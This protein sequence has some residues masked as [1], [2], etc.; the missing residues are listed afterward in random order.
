MV[1][2]RA[3]KTILE[4]QF[5]FLDF[6]LRLRAFHT[7]LRMTGYSVCSALSAEPSF[8]TGF[9]ACGGRRAHIGSWQSGTY[10]AAIPNNAILQQFGYI[11]N[12]V[13]GLEAVG[14][15]LDRFKTGEVVE[16]LAVSACDDCL[17]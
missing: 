5:Q 7:K 8:K 15:D 1:K 11:A 3:S 2:F 13:G 10:G 14:S 16:A 17:C 6:F 4:A 12:V 9:V